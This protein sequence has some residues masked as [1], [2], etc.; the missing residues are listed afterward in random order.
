MVFKIF[1]IFLGV[2]WRDKCSANMNVAIKIITK[3]TMIVTSSI[4]FLLMKDMKLKFKWVYL[5]FYSLLNIM[6]FYK[7]YTIR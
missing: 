5:L 4:D 7:C 3:E 2:F 1:D 6:S